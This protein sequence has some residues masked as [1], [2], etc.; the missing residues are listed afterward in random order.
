MTPPPERDQL[1]ISYSHVD[2]EWVERL[3]TMIRPL[4]RSHGL[5]LWDDSQIQPGDKWREEIE[6]ALAAAKVALLLVSSDFLASEF[7]TNSELPQLLTAAEEEGLRI[8]WVPLRPSLVRV[9]PIDAYQAL[10]DPGRPLARMDPVEQDEALVK[11]ALAIEKALAPLQDSPPAAAKTQ[12]D[13]AGRPRQAA[14]PRSGSSVLPGADRQAVAAA[15]SGAVQPEAAK[16]EVAEPTAAPVP[17]QPYATSTCLLRQEGGRWSMERRS[18]QV[19]GYRVDLGWGVALTM[20]KIPAGSFLMGSPK[21]EPER[22][23]DEGP[24]HEVA[25]SSFFLA[26]TPITQ[27]QWR[28]VAGWQKLERDLEPNPSR[29]MGANRSVEQVSWVDALEFCRRL[30]QRTGQHYGLPREAQW[31]YACRAGSTTPFHCGATLTS[32]LANYDGNHIYGNGPKGIYRKQTIDV[33]S[34]PS[35]GWGLHDMH[36]MVREW[37]EDHWH[38]SYNFAPGDDQP[39]LIPAAADD[40]PRLLRGGSWLNY[41]RHCR[42]ASRYSIQ[43]GH[44]FDCVGFRV[45][46][47]PQGPSLNP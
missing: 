23:E 8:L 38:D 29:F 9:T 47:L 27:A 39:W 46:C 1:F 21:D 10:L 44:A 4:V 11:I 13:S 16:P 3:Q 18:L 7:V 41:P 22:L 33:A 2:R 12:G 35:N 42:S 15:R 36:G 40:E 20:V 30:S 28:A 5:R 45:V 34:F 19:E 25:L 24:Q 43:P 14:A 26:Q 37:C 32:E 17:L 6:T 31:E